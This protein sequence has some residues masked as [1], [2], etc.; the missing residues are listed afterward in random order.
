[1]TADFPC[2]FR[3]SHDSRCYG[4]RCVGRNGRNLPALGLGWTR[5]YL[6]RSHPS[7]LSPTLS[8]KRSH[9]AR[10]MANPLDCCFLFEGSGED[11]FFGPL[12]DF[13][14]TVLCMS[15][16]NISDY[17]RAARPDLYKKLH[18]LPVKSFEVPTLESRPAAQTLDAPTKK[19]HKRALHTRPAAISIDGRPSGFDCPLSSD[20][21]Q[22]KLL[23]IQHKRYI[24][25]RLL[26]K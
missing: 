26:S 1:M 5:L 25:S 8:P 15:E 2:S 3:R 16:S 20:N 12:D 22:T 11:G 6:A 24:Q 21:S 23:E 14:E 4:T 7:W 9:F 19:S 10:D 17:I 18:G 13:T